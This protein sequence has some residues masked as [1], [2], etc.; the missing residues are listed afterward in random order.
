[1]ENISDGQCDGAREDARM[2]FPSI[3]SCN[4]GK[5]HDAAVVSP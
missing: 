4:L 2:F 1:M 5:L 3:G